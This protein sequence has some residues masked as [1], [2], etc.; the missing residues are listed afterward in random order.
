MKS[1]SIERVVDSEEAHKFFRGLWKS[2]IF[3]NAHAKEGSFVYKVIDQ[4]GKYPF[5]AYEMTETDIPG[6]PPIEK[7]HFSAWWRG[8]SHRKYDNPY[9]HD[10]YHFH[11]VYHMALMP[12]IPDMKPQEFMRLIGEN[13][14]DASVM[15]EIIVHL[16][17]PELRKHV[18]TDRKILADRFLEDP[19]FMEMWKSG[20]ID[21]C[22]RIVRSIHYLT[23][24]GICTYDDAMAKYVDKIKERDSLE[25]Q[26]DNL[27]AFIKKANLSSVYQE[28]LEKA[29]SVN[30]PN[31]ASPTSLLA[32]KSAL[33][34]LVTKNHDAGKESLNEFLGKVQGTLLP[35]N[36]VKAYTTYQRWLHRRRSE[37]FGE[38]KGFIDGT[39]EY[40]YNSEHPERKPLIE[41]ADG[42]NDQ[43]RAW[44]RIWS[45]EGSRFNEIENKLSALIKAVDQ[46]RGDPFKTTTRLEFKKYIEWLTSPEVTQGTDIPFYREAYDFRDA[47][48]KRSTKYTQ[49]VEK[50]RQPSGA[51]AGVA[52]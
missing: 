40:I 20:D 27:F 3:K 38:I 42:F 41:F 29:I 21:T 23:K 31:E 46:D 50:S 4:A 18:F 39:H 22:Y 48:L 14:T 7:A 49:V 43:N 36:P 2:D 8:L 12:Y 51:E 30:Y 25:V 34:A 19:K 6:L 17:H 11:E 32:D 45:G 52:M 16:F 33:L 15:S 5:F 1:K 44:K 10:L 26:V 47:Y 24:K 37:W 13:E 35:G 28:N 9:L